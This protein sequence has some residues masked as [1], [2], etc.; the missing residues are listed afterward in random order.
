MLGWTCQGAGFRS[1][2]LVLP[3]TVLATFV[4]ILTLL[5]AGYDFTVVALALVTICLL[6]FHRTYENGRG[7]FRNERRAG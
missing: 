4:P 3:L 6:A 1:L 5:L 2:P 7:P